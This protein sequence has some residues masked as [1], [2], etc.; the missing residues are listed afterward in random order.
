VGTLK[1]A[2]SICPLPRRANYTL[3]QIG[4]KSRMLPSVIGGPGGCLGFT[5]SFDLKKE[6]K[7]K[8]VAVSELALVISESGIR[9]GKKSK[10]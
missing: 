3:V 9:K 10:D 4:P 8:D 1:S 7:K 6:A 5:S 2:P